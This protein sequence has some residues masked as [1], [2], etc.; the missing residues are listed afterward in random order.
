[1]P[2]KIIQDI[3]PTGKRTIRNIPLDDEE[4]ISPREVYKE[5]PSKKGIEI[6]RIVEEPVQDQEEEYIEEPIISP[7]NVRQPGPRSK[8]KSGKY[9]LSFIIVF[10]CIGVIALALSLSYSKAVVTITPKVMEFDINGTFTAKKDAASG[11]LKY[12][13]ITLN[14]EESQSLPATAGSLVE[15]KA[16][17][18][19]IIY[20]NYSASAQTLVAGTRIAE[21]DGLVYRTTSTISV[22]G[23]KT[24]PGNIEVEV[25]ADKAGEEYNKSSSAQ[26]DFQIVAFKGTER[27]DGFY[28]RLKTDI[29][30]GFSGNKMIV[31]EDVKNNA[32]DSMKETLKSKLLAKLDTTTPDDYVVYDSAYNI[33]YEISEPKMLSGNNAEVVVKATAHVP[34]FKSDDLIKYIAGNEIKKFPSETYR[35][36][37]EENLEFKV[38]NTKDF[39]ATRGTP[40]IFTLKGPVSIVGTFPEERLKNEL[41]DISLT[42]SNAV[43]AKY[44]SISNAY[45]LITPFWMRSFPNSPDKIIIEYK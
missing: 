11:D 27:E 31:D 45:A 35:I 39:S 17:G 14:E 30:G 25:V 1:M 15:T 41:K 43:F 34:I 33:Q 44:T 4:I 19:A 7:K 36:E 20:N 26:G 9:I 3:V 37:G 28:A 29:T 2:K 40:L 8:K 42:D 32:V 10:I 16:K 18:K 24:S 13:V 22:P 12:E 5:A 21:D 6:R 38:S 23:K